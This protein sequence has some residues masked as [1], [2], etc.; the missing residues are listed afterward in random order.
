MGEELVNHLSRLPMQQRHFGPDFLAI[1]GTPL[2]QG[3]NIEVSFR[4]FHLDK[5]FPAQAFEHPSFPHEKVFS[6]RFFPL[7]KRDPKAL[8][9]AV[10]FIKHPSALCGVFLNLAEGDKFVTTAFKSRAHN[11]PEVAIFLV[12]PVLVVG[13]NL[14]T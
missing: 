10:N 12:L 6:L 4:D 9:L 7:P 13:H 2:H 14:V 8:V 1:L 11:Q 5:E 3:L